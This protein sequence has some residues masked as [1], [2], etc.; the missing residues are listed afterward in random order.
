MISALII[1]MNHLEANTYYFLNKFQMI[2]EQIWVCLFQ[3]NTETV[4]KILMKFDRNVQQTK[5]ILSLDF[6][7]RFVSVIYRGSFS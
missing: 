5:E 3:H 4:C 1:F 6:R 2:L 7:P